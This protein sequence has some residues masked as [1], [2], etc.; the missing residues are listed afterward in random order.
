M[1]EGA[2]VE[3]GDPAQVLEHPAE[4]RTQRFLLRVLDR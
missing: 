4:E 1:D 2:I 3:Q